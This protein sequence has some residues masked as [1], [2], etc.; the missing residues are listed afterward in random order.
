MHRKI[1]ALVAS[2]AVAGSFASAGSNAA[3]I[4][5]IPAGTANNEFITNVLGLPSTAR[6]EGWFDA[7]LYLI[8]GSGGAQITATFYGAEAGY[9][10]RFGFGGAPA[11]NFAHGGG[12][13]FGTPL[14]TC[15]VNNVASGLLNFQ[16][17]IDGVLGLSNGSN[18]APGSGP[19]FFTTF[20]TSGPFDFDTLING[21]TASSGLSAFLFLDD[22]GAGPDSDYDDM[23]VQLQITQN[24]RVS[25]P[26]P[27]TLGLLGMGLL[28]LGFARR[29]RTR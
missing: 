28:G 11:C 8:A 5:S 16:F 25:V 21:S 4:G 17:L 3:V 6:I 15:T 29:R 7:D 9:R 1:H 12:T 26:E 10:N 18:V 2:I 13:T 14:A 22:N 27:A 20:G 23:V 19:N 24:G